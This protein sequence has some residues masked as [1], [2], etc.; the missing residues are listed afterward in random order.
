MTWFELVTLAF[1]LAMDCTAVALTTGFSA[2]RLRLVDALRLSALFGGF[3]AAMPVLGW[4]LGSRF[5]DAVADSGHWIASG[6]LVGVGVKMIAEAWEEGHASKEPFATGALVSL[7]VATSIDALAI[8][9]T[10][11]LL[12][13][14]LLRAC[15]LIGVI[16]ALM[17]LLAVHLG[18]RFGA[19]YAGKLD[20]LGGVVLLGMA[21]RVLWPHVSAW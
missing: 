14:S 20:V 10:F 5:A 19:R 1:G 9:V 21:L 8:G 3:Q 15:S 6:L 18:A 4:M 2:E 7:A 16:A 13:V 17:S 11:P 12:R